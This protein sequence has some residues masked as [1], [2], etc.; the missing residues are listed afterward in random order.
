MLEENLYEIIKAIHIISIISWMA[1]LLYLPRIFVYHSEIEYGSKT[2]LIFQTMEKRLY[3]Y[4]ATP[5]MSLSIICGI[6]LAMQIGFEFAWLHIKI[7]CVL[8]LFIYHCF[9][10]VWKRNFAKGNNKFSPRFYRIAN[11]IPTILMISIVFLVILKP[12]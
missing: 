6:Y 8:L 4:I 11:E 10:G 3:H 9:L 7:F 5:A 12:F 1:A 2:D